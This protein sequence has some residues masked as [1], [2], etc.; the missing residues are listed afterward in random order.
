MIKT[1]ACLWLSP[2]DRSALEEWVSGRNTPQKLVWRA[3]IIL[4]SADRV[5][6]MA[7]TRAVGMSK[8]TVARWQERYLAKGI[9]GLQRDASR[10]GRLKPLSA[11]TIE[12]VV[13]KTL[14]EKPPKGTRWSIRKMAKASGLSYSS[15]QRIWKAHK[16]K[17]YR[18]KTFKLSNDKLFVD[19]VQDIVG[20]YLNPPDKAL[21]FSLDEKTQIQALDRTQP[22]LPLKKGRCGTMTHDYKR[23]GTTTLFA[24]LDVATG[25]VIGQCMP[26]HR[27]QE[28][29]KFLRRIDAETPGHLDL[30]LIADN[31]A[32]H[33]H[34]KVMA[35]LERH[36]RFHMH[37]TPTSASW[38]NQVERFFGLITGDRIRCGV[39]KSVSELVDAINQYLD[40][41]N[42]DPKPFVWTASAVEILE[43]VARGRKT[44]ESLH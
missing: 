28:W 31:Y 7:I 24:A 40:Q 2:A 9:A 16:L 15:V 44:L 4:L 1:K 10:P 17:P 34:P 26:R 23:H 33:K 25:K 27:H 3:R 37:F 13:H 8:V 12:R 14:H 11:D 41:H 43:K 30:H 18:V 36:K 20:L 5:G 32:T 29:L 38:L 35:W 22:G 39:F 19:K 42:A 6:V 21:V